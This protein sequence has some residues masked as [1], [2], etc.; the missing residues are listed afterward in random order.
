MFLVSMA[1]VNVIIVENFGC[2]SLAFVVIVHLFNDALFVA[3]HPLLVANFV[4]EP[5]MMG[6]HD[7]ATAEP[8]E[9]A[10]KGIDRIG[11]EIIGRLIQCHKMGS[12]PEGSTK[13]ELGLLTGGERSDVT[14]AA[15]FLVDAELLEVLHDFT[16]R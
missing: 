7:N 8:L 2:L 12:R 5:L 9:R 16:T 10:S 13:S 15:H 11:I 3:D 4:D 14:I 6:N 1:A